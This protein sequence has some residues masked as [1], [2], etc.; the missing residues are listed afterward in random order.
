MSILKNYVAVD[1]ET[2]GLEAKRDRIIEIGA[3]RVCDGE[4]AEVNDWLINPRCALSDFIKELTKINEEMLENAPYID[5]VIREF[6]E[7]CG[8][9]VLLGHNIMFDY[10]FLKRNAV[11][12]GIMFEKCGI[13][14]L[15]AARVIFADMEKKN[16]GFLCKN[17]GINVEH[18]HRATDDALAASELFKRM[19][20]IAEGNEELEKLLAPTQLV[21][22]V[23]K[24]GPIT[25]A[26]KKY[27]TYLFS[28]HGLR[29]DR[30]MDS[31]TKNEASRYIDNIIKN[32]GRF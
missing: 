31:M 18:E 25:A 10:G 5:E 20:E 27:L 19:A 32:Y 29:M 22:A 1:I 7:F 13:D 8:D 16:L 14:T 2:T 17:L 26:Q 15:K 24:E 12:Q 30:D 6:A 28:L 23:K 4:I 3:I 21:Y 9:D 11:N